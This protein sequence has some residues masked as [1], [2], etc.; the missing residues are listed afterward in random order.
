MYRDAAAAPG[1]G[2]C[3]KRSRP[4]GLLGGKL[5]NGAMARL[6]AEQRPAKLDRVLAGR[7]RQLIDESLGRERSMRR[8]YRAPPLH[9]HS[10]LGRMEIDKHVGDRIRQGRGAFDRRRVDTVLD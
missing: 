2:R 4:S 10:Q 3:R 1:T 9:G 6:R 5:Q 8:A 7:G